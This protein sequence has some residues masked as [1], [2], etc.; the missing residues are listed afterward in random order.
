MAANQKN[1]NLFH[2]TDDNAT[3]WNLRGPIDTA[4]NAVDGSAPLTAGAPVWLNSARRRAR[5][6]IF[7]DPTTFRT[8]KFPVFTPTAFA[9]ITGASTLAVSVPGEATTVTYNLSQ[10]VAEKQPIAKTSRNLAD[11]A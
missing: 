11:H 7:F 5:H 2:Y 9:A 8:I 4:I 1:T 10:K 6:A 3:V